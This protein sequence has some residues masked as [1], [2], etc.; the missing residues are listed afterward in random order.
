[1]HFYIALAFVGAAIVQATSA[2]TQ[3]RSVVSE[4]ASLPLQL[5]EIDPPLE[6]GMVSS[7]AADGDGLI[8]ALQRGEKSDPIVVMDSSGKVVRSW[9][10]GMYVIPH[11]IRIDPQGYVWT[12]DAGSS[13]VYK[14]DRFGKKLLEIQVGL[15][16][17]NPR[18]GFHGATDIAFASSGSF[19]VSDGYQ[20]AR[21]LKFDS[22][23]KK[24]LEWG[25]SGTGP[26]EFN[27]PHGIA[28]GTDGTVYVADR[29]NLRIQ[30]FD[31]EGRFLRK[32]NLH[33]K[34]FSLKSTSSDELWAGI[35][36]HDVPNG[37]EGWLMQLDQ[38]KQK[39][40]GLV[41]AFGH[42]MEVSPRGALLTGHRDGHVLMFQP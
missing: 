22:E 42:S 31:P 40:L 34:V 9:G 20:N 14:F 30:V 17:E 5:S 29:E 36:P 25:S 35:Q 23:G 11:N 13:R 12:V 19:Y 21:I 38:E 3:L 24:I 4:T 41:E 33:G 15:P 8:Y 2:S 6:M 26:G 32:W 1:M 28:V 10:R 16:P 18:G 37:S 7:V 27:L 39:V